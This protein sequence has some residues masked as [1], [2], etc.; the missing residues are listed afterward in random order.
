MKE[1]FKAGEGLHKTL[2][3]FEDKRRG[4]GAQTEE[5]GWPLEAGNAIHVARK[6]RSQSYEHKELNFVNNSVVICHSS[7][8][9]LKT[10]KQ[11]NNSVLICHSINK[12]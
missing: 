7:N 10:N 5:Y 6:W 2:L 12:T 11:P 8:G 3:N 1:R 4:V 9:K